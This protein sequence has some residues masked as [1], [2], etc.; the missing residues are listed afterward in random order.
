LSFKAVRGMKDI[1]PGEVEVWTHLEELARRV[2]QAYR[3]REI[4]TPIVEETELFVRGVGETSDIVSKQMYAFP[5]RK[6]RSLALR[7]EG[8]APVIRA[9]LEHGLQRQGSLLKLFYL[10]PFFSLRAAAGRKKKAISSAG[11]GGHWLRKSGSRCRS[12]FSGYP[13]S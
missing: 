12:D 1:L 7:P 10:G 6:G 8:T 13:S 2:F 5:D 11:S 9:C 4:R 3:Y